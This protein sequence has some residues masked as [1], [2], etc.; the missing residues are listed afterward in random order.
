MSKVAGIHNKSPETYPGPR[1]KS[2]VLQ[3]LSKVQPPGSVP[4]SAATSLLGAAG[5]LMFTPL[6]AANAV[7]LFSGVLQAGSPGT[8]TVSLVDLTTSTTESSITVEV[9]AGTNPVPFSMV[10]EVTGLSAGVPQT[11]DVQGTTAGT[12][13]ALDSSLVA[14]VATA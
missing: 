5:P 3:T 7:F 9:P 14:I 13:S 1:A 12:S 2:T 8:T 4:L 10:F 11:F 6:V